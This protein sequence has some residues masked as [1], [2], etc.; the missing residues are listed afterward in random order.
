MSSRCK[1]SA[2]RVLLRAERIRGLA[3]RATLAALVS[4][5]GGNLACQTFLFGPDGAC[6][7]GDCWNG[8][9]VYEWYDGPYEGDRYEGGWL[10]GLP[11]GSGTYFL[12]SVRGQFQGVF[13]EGKRHCNQCS[14]V[15]ET[16]YK[17]VANYRRGRECGVVK[18]FLPDGETLERDRG[19]CG[20]L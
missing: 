18:I 5:A 1:N 2:G 19:E 12:Q 9:G 8:Q 7:E 10:D 11:H 17:V 15:G 14:T 20:P 16:G 13:L 4:F 3:R 6:V